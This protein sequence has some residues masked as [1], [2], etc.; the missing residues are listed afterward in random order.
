MRL[1]DTEHVFEDRGLGKEAWL[2]KTGCFAGRVR[3]F[4]RITKGLH[5]ITTCRWDIALVSQLFLR[6]IFNEAGLSLR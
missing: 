6:Q 1:P 5:G 3:V 2:Q 4:S